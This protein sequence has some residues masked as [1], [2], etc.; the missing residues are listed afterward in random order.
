MDVAQYFYIPYLGYNISMPQLGREALEAIHWRDVLHSEMEDRFNARIAASRDHV[1]FLSISKS[2]VKGS[3]SNTR[4]AREAAREIEIWNS[5]FPAWSARV[6][7]AKIG[8][9]WVSSVLGGSN[10]PD[11]CISSHINELL[12]K[13]LRKTDIE[14][15]T[16]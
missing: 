10:G 6:S 7:N 9:L 12:S 8:G 3:M 13:P 15:P 16:Q 1:I 14:A 11:I 5:H 4:F 2:R